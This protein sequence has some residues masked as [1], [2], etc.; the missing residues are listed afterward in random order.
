L[1]YRVYASLVLDQDRRDQDRRDKE[2]VHSNIR[3]T[4]VGVLVLFV[5]VVLL[6]YWLED[7]L[8]SLT[9]WFD[10][11]LGL[12]GLAFLMFINDT[13]I[14]PLPPDLVLFIFSKSARADSAPFVIT[15]FGVCSVVA[16]M[17]GWWIGTRLHN[18]SIP[19]KIFGDQLEKS[20][21][22]AK[23]YGSW[24]LLLGALTPI[25]YSLTTWTAGMMGLSFKRVIWPCLARIPRFWIYYLIILKANK[26]S[27][28]MKVLFMS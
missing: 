19:K 5:L 3:K 13:F 26:L 21:R 8:V 25:P 4:L 27:E 12:G 14:S 10:R 28:W 7:E 23:K 1:L 20:E 9:N 16:G 24:A 11:S 22:L 2:E 15:L 17:V 6:G 18:T